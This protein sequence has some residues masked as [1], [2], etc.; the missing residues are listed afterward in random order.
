MAWLCRALAF[1]D[2]GYQEN[3]IGLNRITTVIYCFYII[4]TI[5]IS[6]F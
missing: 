4:F 1:G 5:H 3:V 6:W 2:G